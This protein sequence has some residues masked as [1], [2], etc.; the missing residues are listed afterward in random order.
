MLHLH[1]ES[2]FG[3]LRVLGG[4]A[5]KVRLGTL[6]DLTKL[7]Q[8]TNLGEIGEPSLKHRFSDVVILHTPAHPVRMVT[9]QD[10]L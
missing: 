6:R 7:L 1:L 3:P 2:A 8:T 9:R 5:A 10:D 4:Q